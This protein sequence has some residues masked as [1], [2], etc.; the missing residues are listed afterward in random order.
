MVRGRF[1]CARA[2]GPARVAC[3]SFSCAREPGPTRVVGGSFFMPVSEDCLFILALAPRRLPMHMHRCTVSVR[4]PAAVVAPHRYFCRK[5]VDFLCVGHLTVQL[6]DVHRRGAHG[7]RRRY[8]R[9]RR[10]AGMRP[11][12]ES[13]DRHRQ[14][15]K[16]A[17]Q[18]VYVRQHARSAPTQ[19]SAQYTP[20]QAYAPTVYAHPRTD[21]QP[22]TPL[23]VCV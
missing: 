9:Q 22:R 6:P 10:T 12:A 7:H 8:T 3:G 5:R 21:D 2:P 13:A 15:L 4:G 19:I 1:S 17:V 23:T 18:D 11:C 14:L 20:N 16:L